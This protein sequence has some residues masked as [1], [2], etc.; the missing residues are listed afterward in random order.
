MNSCETIFCFTKRGKT[1]IRR[2]EEEG[3]K[4][5]KL[6]H[7]GFYH[8]SI[9]YRLVKIGFLVRED[10]KNIGLRVYLSQIISFWRGI[11]VGREPQRKYWFNN[12]VDFPGKI[13]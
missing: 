7:Y 9:K 2:R 3:G 4:F 6:I 11:T 5:N 13:S 8:L 12:F 1:T 10:L